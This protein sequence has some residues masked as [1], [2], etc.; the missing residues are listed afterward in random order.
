[1]SPCSVG[2]LMFFFVIFLLAS[3]RCRVART[4]FFFFRAYKTKGED[5][6]SSFVNRFNISF[7]RF[8]T[9]YHHPRTLSNVK[10]FFP[11]GLVGFFCPKFTL[12][13]R[14]SAAFDDGVARYRF[15]RCFEF[16]DILRVFNIEM[17]LAG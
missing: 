4:C 13:K 14:N 8:S 17:P 5:S 3:A 11:D 10:R 6:L 9:F 16:F 2:N 7:F 12:R 15:A 1:M